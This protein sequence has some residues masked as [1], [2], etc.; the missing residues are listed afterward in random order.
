MYRESYLMGRKIFVEYFT[1][2]YVFSP[3]TVFKKKKYDCA[4]NFGS[5]ECSDLIKLDM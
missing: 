5:K 1:K 4:V 2:I 3:N